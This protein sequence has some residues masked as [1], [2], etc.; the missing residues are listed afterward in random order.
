MLLHV[1]FAVIVSLVYFRH[2]SKRVWIL[3]ILRKHDIKYYRLISPCQ[4]ETNHC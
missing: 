3:A 2:Y 1:A 4:G